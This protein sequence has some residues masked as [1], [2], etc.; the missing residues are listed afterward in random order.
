LLAVPV[1]LLLRPLVAVPRRRVVHGLRG[2]ELAHA[3]AEVPAVSR[4]VQ[5]LQA[6]PPEVA[7]AELL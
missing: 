4:K 7:L 2:D 3:L 5:A 1:L 6:G